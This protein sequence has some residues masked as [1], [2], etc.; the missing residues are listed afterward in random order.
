MPEL[1][2]LR[3]EDVCRALESIG[4]YRKSQRGSHLKLRHA[5]GRTVIVPV[6]YRDIPT[7]SDHPRLKGRLRFSVAG[8]A[9]RGVDR[10][11]GRC[12]RP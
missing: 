12:Q 9:R 2:V 11:S 5:D 1:P 4:F 3:W 10:V 8:E 7:H 6:H